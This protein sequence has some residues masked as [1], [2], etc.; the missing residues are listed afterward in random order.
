MKLRLDKYLTLCDLGTRSEMQKLVHSER[1]K[2]NGYVEKNSGTHVLPSTSFVEL[3]DKE[4]NFRHFVYIMLNKPEGYLSATKDRTRKTIMDLLP[5]WCK[6]REMAPIGRLDIDTTGL[7]FITDDGAFNHQLTSPRMHVNKVYRAEIDKPVLEEHIKAFAA[8]MRF[9]DFT[10]EIAKLV[11]V[12]SRYKDEYAAQ[13]TLHEGKYHQVKRMFAACGINVI[14]LERIKIGSIS[15][16]T[17]MEHGQW[18]EFTFKE[19]KA[20]N[21]NNPYI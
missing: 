18:R 13:V 10:A 17:D 16:P 12:Q 20:F 2:V 3:D 15:L 1:I 14:H 7:L 4:L 19:I 6:R 11:P 21:I 5:D 9:K 8:G